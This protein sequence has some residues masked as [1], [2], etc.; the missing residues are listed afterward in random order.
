MSDAY[1]WR[2]RT[3]A[4]DPRHEIRFGSY[5]LRPPAR[6]LERGGEPVPLGSRALDLLCLLA[7]RPGEVIRK[8]ELMA[9]A[10]PDL[11][12][13]ESSLRF[14]IAQ[15]RRALGGDQE[16]DRYIANVPGRGYC[17]VAAVQRPERP[18]ASALDGPELAFRA[19]LPRRVA[20]MVGRETALAAISDL[21]ADRRFITIRG[22]GGI[23]KTTVAVALAHDLAGEFA[24]GV[25]FLDLGSLQDPQLVPS[26]MATALGL[27]VPSA[28]P[29]PALIGFLRDRR[30]LLVLDSCEHVIEVAASLAEQI[31]HE[32]PEVSL[33][34][35]SREALR[36][37]GEQVFDLPP[38]D[39][40]PSAGGGTAA[41][42]LA[43][44]AASL[45]AERA[46]AAGY[47]LPVSDADARI[48]AAICQRLDGVALAIELVAGRVV[49]HGLAATAEL[50][51]GRL[52][53]NWRGRRTAP[54]RH[55]TLSAALDWSY[56]L[57]SE[58]ERALLRRL[59]V[60]PGRFTLDGARAVADPSNSSADSFVDALDQLVSKSLVASVPD[61]TKPQ[62]RLLDTT[63]TYAFAKLT[64][65]KEASEACGRHAAW[66]C[67]ALAA[68]KTAPAVRRRDLIAD[69]RT[70]LAW[71]YA[72]DG[73]C[74]LRLP[75]A[76]ACARLFVE[77]NLLQECQIWAHRAI[78]QLPPD[79]SPSKSEIELL[80]ALGHALMFT[81]AN[82]DQSQAVLLRG[83]A[84]A[85]AL[86]DDAG[87]FRILSRLHALYRRT[88][89][90]RPLLD[91]A[92][93]AH[94]VA[95]RIGDPAGVSRAE[96]LLGVAHHLAGDQKAA[97][98]HLQAAQ[99]GDAAI[100]GLPAGHFAGFRGVDIMRCTNLWVLGL[101]DQALEVAERV[102]SG[103]STPD[104][105]MYCSGLSLS[106]L[107]F[108]WAGDVTGLEDAADRLAAHAQR[109]GLPPFHA[110]AVTL[111]AQALL[112]RG[113]L[114]SGVELLDAWLPR[115][116][117]D[118]NE[119]YLATGASA[120]AEGLAAQ[121]RMPEALGRIEQTI[122]RVARDGESF[123]LP[124]LI[125][126]RGEVR[127][128]AGE[129]DA[130]ARDFTA[131]LEMADAHAALSWRLRIVT[132]IA[133]HAR[134]AEA[135]AAAAAELRGVC[136][137]FTEGFGTADL[138]AARR[139]LA[140]LAPA[141]VGA[142]TPRTGDA[143]TTA[144]K[145]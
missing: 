55:Q 66:V 2:R 100:P 133:R 4:A 131:A 77:E 6:L 117:A 119:L 8:D 45:F 121:G 33:I 101:P 144:H 28:D 52:R 115:L 44:P 105:I 64:E 102:K 98:A 14:H 15:L 17:F 29:T 112:M 139:L 127:A 21:L 40:P 99:S 138:R 38:L 84:T 75:L 85:R 10:W 18:R 69:A 56:A 61:G 108:R 136:A 36:V 87:E 103:A 141:A 46:A 35:T 123:D 114:D 48:V 86:G 54:A 7:S 47:S 79:A 110:V 107:V 130:A 31:H 106:A 73:P 142:S 68:P 67:Q 16:G 62:L 124:E 51:D 11:T 135:R 140:E 118:R 27:L 53:L 60:F 20:R 96:A 122:E 34:V 143:L 116:H 41:E 91:V 22:P 95:A 88:G 39:G 83:L 24:D 82:N 30:M 43:Y 76:A 126:V 129:L 134:G 63:R 49:A 145:A 57:V 70:A 26:T 80:W 128:A 93:R 23:G 137:R 92:R 120:L 37:E 89:E 13:E 94:A 132:S 81:E 74:E 111:K 59:S 32:A 50:L 113:A 109:H 58:P 97:F 9:S 104:L 72:E 125:R 12:V 71:T 25:R 3:E 78:N 1:E 19:D 5:R 65:L 90:L 42:I